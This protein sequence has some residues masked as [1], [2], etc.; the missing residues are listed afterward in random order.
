MNWTLIYTLGFPSA[1]GLI[2]LTNFFYWRYKSSDKS[3]RACIDG[4]IWFMITSAIGE[5]LDHLFYPSAYAG[6]SESAAQIF[7]FL[8]ALV[9]SPF[10]S[11]AGWAV[12]R[13]AI[14]LKEKAA[15]RAKTSAE[16]KNEQ[17]QNTDTSEGQAA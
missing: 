17:N 8:V 16:S 3:M 6:L 10:V 7:G 5:G 9:A 14:R 4:W 12:T 13:K 15:H 2:L 1:L 11:F